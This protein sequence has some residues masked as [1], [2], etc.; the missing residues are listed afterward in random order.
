MSRVNIHEA[1]KESKG[2]SMVAGDDKLVN[3]IRRRRGAED[4][5]SA[6]PQSQYCVHTV[7]PLVQQSYE[8]SASDT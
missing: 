7:A 5:R 2:I 6:P 4:K 1:I 8:N 3:D